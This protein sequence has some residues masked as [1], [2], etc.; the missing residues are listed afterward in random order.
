MTTT[1]ALSEE[2]LDNKFTL[3]KK[4]GEGFSA[5]VKLATSDA[6]GR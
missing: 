5:Q 1:M 4:L 6:D 2:R 3:T